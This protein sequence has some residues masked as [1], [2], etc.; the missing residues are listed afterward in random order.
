VYMIH[1]Y[2]PMMHHPPN[3]R[4]QGRGKDRQTNGM[5]LILALAARLK[6]HSL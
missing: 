4:K 6:I 1:R 2:L 3:W 5:R